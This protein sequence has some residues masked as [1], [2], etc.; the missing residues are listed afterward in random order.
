[1]TGFLFF[2]SLPKRHVKSNNE[3]N[4]Y[5]NCFDYPPGFS[6]CGSFY[7]STKRLTESQQDPLF[8]EILSLCRPVS[9]YEVETNA[10]VI[11]LS[12]EEDDV[13]FRFED[14]LADLLSLLN[15]P[16]FIH[17]FTQK[18][19]GHDDSFLYARCTRCT[20]MIHGVDFFKRVLEGKEKDF[21]ANESE[22]VLYI[23]KEAWARKH[24]SDVESFPHSSKNALYF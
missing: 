23:A 15:K 14:T 12:Q 10:A 21:W 20:A 17:S 6:G 4:V 22:G 5:Q 19:I 8:W 18:N 2:L 24:G 1:M 3:N 13:I 9:E 16:Y 7:L 11:R